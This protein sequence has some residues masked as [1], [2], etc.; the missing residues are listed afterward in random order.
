M[1][2]TTCEICNSP[3]PNI[4]E[5]NSEGFYCATCYYKYESQIL[6]DCDGNCPNCEGVENGR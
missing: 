3:S 1:S 2:R 6:C 4:Y 5:P